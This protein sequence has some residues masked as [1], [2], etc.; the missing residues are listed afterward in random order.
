LEDLKLI[1]IFPNEVLEM[2]ELNP[3]LAQHLDEMMD[4]RRLKL[5]ELKKN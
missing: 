3:K 4:V 1:T 5:A 2:V